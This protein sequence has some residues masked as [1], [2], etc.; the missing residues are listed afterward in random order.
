MPYA[1]AKK[2][3]AQATR[4]TKVK[5][6][7]DYQVHH[8][9]IAQTANGPIIHDET[10]PIYIPELKTSIRALVTNASNPNLL[11]LGL[12]VRQNGF[13]QTFNQQQGW[14][15]TTPC[16]ITTRCG[17]PNDVP[18]FYTVGTNDP[19]QHFMVPLTDV[20]SNMKFYGPALEK[21]L[22][23]PDANNSDDTPPHTH[24]FHKHRRW[25]R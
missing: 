13:R 14:L 9:V 19:P 8:K 21:D 15:L 7:Q 12:L 11:S 17:M 16:G 25:H 24:T 2:E 6:N 18:Y 3:K 23:N 10:V 4:E 22:T 20:S 1:T 5:N